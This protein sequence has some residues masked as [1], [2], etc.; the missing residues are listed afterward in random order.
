MLLR[1]DSLFNAE[2]AVGK[3][4]HVRP[5]E[6]L[7]GVMLQSISQL[8]NW[9]KSEAIEFFVFLMNPKI[10]CHDHSILQVLMIQ[11]CEDFLHLYW[12]SHKKDIDKKL[13]LGATQGFNSQPGGDFH[14]RST[15]GC[16]TS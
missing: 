12:V 5:L 7:C 10:R 8:L 4:Q 11:G 3:Q 9:M 2:Y 13:L 1:R 16:A 15:R 6:S 14:M